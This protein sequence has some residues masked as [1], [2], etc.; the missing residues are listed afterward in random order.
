MHFESRQKFLVFERRIRF[1]F[2]R[3]FGCKLFKE[4]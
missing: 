3:N 1:G 2:M 4:E